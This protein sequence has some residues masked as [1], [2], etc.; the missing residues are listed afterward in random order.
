MGKHSYKL[1]IAATGSVAALKIPILL[2]SLTDES[3]YTFEVRLILTEHAKNFFDLSELPPEVLIYDDKS[4][5]ETWKQRG[6]PVLHIELGKWADMMVIAPLDAN[7]LAKMAQGICDNLVTCTTRA[8]DMTKPLLFCP[9]MNTRMWEHPI[10]AKQ[11]A[12]LKEWGH[13][14]IPPISKTLICGDT[15]VGAM[16]E[17]SVI[18]DTIKKRSSNT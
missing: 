13:T 2:K 9:A 1:L 15:G 6:D 14:E 4:E 18:V 10:T 3:S 7:T 5:W 11:V 16:A 12:S 17:V 8:W